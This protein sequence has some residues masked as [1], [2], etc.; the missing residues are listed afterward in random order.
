MDVRL[1]QKQEERLRV[2]TILWK[3]KLSEGVLRPLS[4]VDRY[5]I[6]ES[7]GYLYAFNAVN[8]TMADEAE[9]SARMNGSDAHYFS[10]SGLSASEVTAAAGTPMEASPPMTN[11]IW[12]LSSNRKIYTK[13]GGI[14]GAPLAA[15]KT[16]FFGFVNE[17]GRSSVIAFDLAKRRVAWERELAGHRI[18]LKFPPVTDGQLVYFRTLSHLVAVSA[19]DGRAVWVTKLTGKEKEEGYRDVIYFSA[20]LIYDRTVYLLRDEYLIPYRTKDGETHYNS[21]RRYLGS[22]GLNAVE[23]ASVPIVSRGRMYTAGSLYFLNGTMRAASGDPGGYSRIAAVDLSEKR[24]LWEADIDRVNVRK[25]VI[26]GKFLIISDHQGRVQCL[27]SRT[28]RSL[29]GAELEGGVW[30]NP[31]VYFG[32]VF[33]G[34]DQ[35]WLYCMAL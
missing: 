28:G 5:L 6:L 24:T 34:T 11:R 25:I 27:S 8:G 21:W 10:F 23:A 22:I 16:A 7:E 14:A 29:W 33:F 19:S 12:D 3:R 1:Q 35:G 18:I 26:A 32:R 17:W 4:I 30:V 2:G 15:G 13:N 9:Y 20:P 31:V